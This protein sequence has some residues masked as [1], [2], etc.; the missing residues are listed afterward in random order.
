MYPR[1]YPRLSAYSFL[2]S[3]PG[4]TSCEIDNVYVMPLINYPAHE[5]KTLT[6]SLLQLHKLNSLFTGP[7]SRKPLCVWMDTD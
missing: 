2:L 3:L 7:E 1:W 4:K 6:T 5:W